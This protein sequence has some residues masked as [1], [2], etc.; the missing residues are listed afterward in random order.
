[1]D[2]LGKALELVGR[3]VILPAGARAVLEACDDLLSESRDE[4]PVDQYDLSNSGL[5]AAEIDGDQ[6]HG[7]V[8]YDTPYAVIQ[9]EA[10]EFQHQDGRKAGYLR[11]PL[12]ANA[13]RYLDY[14]AAAIR[15][16]L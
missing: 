14:I 13:N 1:V 10:V 11:D 2:D 3:Q 4:I 8:G 9:H 12:H 16:V 6:V 7:A 15:G 5:A